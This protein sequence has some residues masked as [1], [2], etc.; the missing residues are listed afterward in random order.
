MAYLSTEH[1][2]YIAPSQKDDL[3]QANMRNMRCM[4]CMYLLCMKLQDLEGGPW[5]RGHASHAVRAK[6]HLE[7]S[8]KRAC[9][10]GCPGSWQLKYPQKHHQID[11]R[12]TEI[13]SHSF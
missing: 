6:P 4:D 5:D 8:E 11:R 3:P 13:V 2:R 9:V 7:L 1:C 10:D 12:S